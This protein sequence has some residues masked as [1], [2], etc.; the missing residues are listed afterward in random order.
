MDRLVRR[1]AARWGFKVA[2]S[3]YRPEIPQWVFDRYATKTS[4]QSNPAIDAEIL[5]TGRDSIS[6]LL[7]SFLSILRRSLGDRYSMNS[8][9]TSTD[10]F[11]FFAPPQPVDSVA[12]HIGCHGGRLKLDIS[13]L[14]R[15]LRGGVNL[16]KIVELREVIDDPEMTGLH[17]MR[18]LKKIMAKIRR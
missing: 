5:D 7:P 1:V 6:A 14:P 2:M 9:Q 13:Y 10:L 8:S 17:M 16:S 11:Y 15:D 4:F 3:G 18:M 12:M